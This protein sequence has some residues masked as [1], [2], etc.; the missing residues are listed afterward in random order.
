MRRAPGQKVRFYISK[1]GL[2]RQLRN[3]PNWQ[4]AT[5]CSCFKSSC[6]EACRHAE[7]SNKNTK[8]P[9]FSYIS[10]NFVQK[11]DCIKYVSCIQ[12]LAILCII[13]GPGTFH[14]KKLLPKTRFWNLHAL[15]H[16]NLPRL[17]NTERTRWKKSSSKMWFIIGRLLFWK[18]SIQYSI[19]SSKI[20]FI[21]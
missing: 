2:F 17:I 19:F 7:N 21:M 5:N 6:Q 4:I 1:G 15:Q 11:W 18:Y 10:F 14:P 20:W 8:A 3:L 13:V 12:Y 16:W 9:L